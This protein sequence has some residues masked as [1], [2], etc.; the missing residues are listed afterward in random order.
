M[1]IIT[2]VSKTEFET[3]DGAIHPILF[4]LDETP[5][6][7]QFQAQ[8]DDWF[9]VFSDRGLTN[10]KNNDRDRRSGQLTRSNR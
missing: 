6:V 9:G 4:E 2:K 7:A 10:E 8:Y 1:T 3:D 5:T